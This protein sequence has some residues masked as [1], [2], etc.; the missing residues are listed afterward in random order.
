MVC[1]F[2]ERMVQ[3]LGTDEQSLIASR[4][5]R[6]SEIMTRFTMLVSLSEKMMAMVP[7]L[8]LSRGRNSSAM[9][10]STSASQSLLAR[11]MVAETMAS[12]SLLGI[13]ATSPKSMSASLPALG[14]SVICSTTHVTARRVCIR[15][16]EDKNK[17][18]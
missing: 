17:E 18:T 13:S 5:T 15:R 16:Q 14:P 6:A 11:W 3:A 7:H 8:S 9:K 2:F 12:R 10:S 1:N 4:V